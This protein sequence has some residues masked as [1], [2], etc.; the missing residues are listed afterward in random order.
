MSAEQPLRDNHA[1][2]QTTK[3]ALLQLR[4]RKADAES[5]LRCL[6]EVIQHLERR[7]KEYEKPKKS[8]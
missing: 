4:R 5:E 7:Q 8:L 6:N 3:K 2:L 1:R